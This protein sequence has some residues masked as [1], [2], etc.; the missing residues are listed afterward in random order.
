MM[1]LYRK[2]AIGCRALLLAAVL[3]GALLAA[4]ARA[5]KSF[6]AGEQEVDIADIDLVRVEWQRGDIVIAADDTLRA[7]VIGIDKCAHRKQERA[8]VGL[9]V[10]PDG[11]LL[12]VA[13][14]IGN[15]PGKERLAGKITLSLRVPPSQLVEVR[16]KE[17]DLTASGLAGLAVIQGDGDATIH[18]IG[19][20]LI[21]VRDEG[22]ELD[23]RDSADIDIRYWSGKR[24]V[25]RDVE[26][27]RIEGAGDGEIEIAGVTAGVGVGV[28][29][30]GNIEIDA[31][32]GDVLIGSLGRANLRVSN[33]GGSVGLS[34]HQRGNVRWEAVNGDVML[35]RGHPDTPD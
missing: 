31:V 16:Q 11:R 32:G 8:L 35:P 34:Q 28:K 27:V 4:P 14:D 6:E 18:S 20:T 17:G 33:I 15:R 25:V 30:D 24:L 22:G 2:S 21:V 13:T 19:D 3:A 12:R 23:I 10:I 9:R 5:C 7:A 26:S 1:T 29:T